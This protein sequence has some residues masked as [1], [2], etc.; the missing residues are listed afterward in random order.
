[1]ASTHGRAWLAGILFLV[2]AD[3][4]AGAELPAGGGDVAASR[5]TVFM[6]VDVLPMS[7]DVLLRDQAVLVRNGRIVSVSPA[8]ETQ[9]PAEAVRI[10]GRGKVLMP[11]LTEM[12]GHVP[13]GEDPQYVED[14]LFLFLANGVTTVRNMS[15]DPSHVALRERLA[16]GDAVGPTLVAASPWLQGHSAEEID[17]TLRRHRDAGY[18]L[19]KIG[20][21]DA[22]LYPGMARA[23]QALGLPFAGHVPEGVSLETALSARQASIDHF[24]RYA[25]FLVPADAKVRARGAGFFGSGWV[26]AIDAARIPAAV[27]LT[28]EAGTWNVPTL[29]LVEHLA[30]REPVESMIA[31][32][33]MR[34]MPPRVRDGWVRAKREFGARDDFQPDA[35]G[36]LLAVRRQ[37]LKAL[38]DGGAPIALGSDAPQF[39]NV[40]GFSIHREMAMM[41]AAG[42]TPFQV[43]AT[44]TTAPAQYL[45]TPEAFGQVAPG[46]RADL[47]LLDGDPREHIAHASR[48]VGVMVRGQ[49]W[50][51]H[52][53]EAR[54]E[55]IAA[56]HAAANE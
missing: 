12:H 16:R 37:L 15:G 49:W 1:M 40:P 17:A 41:V 53:I 45:G 47:L 43:L 31:W 38:H 3:N 26:D 24:D 50:P 22:A 30:S 29:S 11:G 55:R 56:R 48:P 32:P 42:L 27:R 2:L 46:H 25:E 14:V 13:G 35:A 51:S 34:Y 4:T 21:F 8:V 9:A 7:G 5:A 10:D 33:E 23:A 44:G 28:V 36:R 19:V 52:E 20:S 18:D 54:L 6:H 39:F